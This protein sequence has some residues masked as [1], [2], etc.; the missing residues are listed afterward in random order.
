M[1][2]LVTGGAGIVGSHRVEVLLGRGEAVIILR[3]LSAGRLQHVV[4][5]VD[6][7]HVQSVHDT[8]LNR[9]AVGVLVGGSAR[10]Y[11]LAGEDAV[12]PAMGDPLRWTST[13]GR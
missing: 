11:H 9:A 13:D 2:A 3:N 6:V 4:D 8:I 5:P 1:K 10:I 7:G 12:K